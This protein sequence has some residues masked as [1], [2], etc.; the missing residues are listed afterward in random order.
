[1]K[2]YRCCIIRRYQVAFF[3]DG[4]KNH[5]S[6]PALFKR[7]WQSLTGPRA[8]DSDNARLEYM[9]KVILVFNCLVILPFL[10]ISIIGAFTKKTPLDTTIWLAL[11]LL[12]FIGGWIAANRGYRKVGGFITS[13]VFLLV[14]AYGNY[15]GGIDA[16]AMLLYALAII[17]AAI[18]MGW[19]AQLVVLVLSLVSFVGFGFAHHIHLLPAAR[20]AENMFVNRISIVVACLAVIA[21][22]VWFL[23]YQYQ[24]SINELRTSSKKNRALL[25]TISDGVVYS[26]LEGEIVDLNEGAATMFKLPDRQSVLG[27][28]IIEFLAPE[29]QKLADGLHDIL[30]TN[31]STGSIKCTGLL[32]NGSRIFLEINSA[33]FLD[34]TGKPTGFVSTMRDITQ[35]KQI[36]DELAKYREQLENL[37]SERTAELKDAYDEMESFSYSISHDLRSPLRGID[38][39]TSLVARDP[40]NKLSPT[41]LTYIDHIRTSTHRMADLISDLLDFSRLIRHPLSCRETHPDVIA[42]EVKEELLK[43]DYSS[44]DFEISIEKMPVCFADPVLLRQVYFNLLDNAFKYSHK[45]ERSVIKV[46][47]KTGEQNEIIYFVSDNGIGFDM[48]YAEKL[49][50]MFQRLHTDPDYKGTGIGLATVQRIIQRHNGKIWVTSKINE[51]T[52]FY[53]TLNNPQLKTIS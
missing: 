15:V 3:Q 1:M 45:R 13:V 35:R 49:F 21:L 5:R 11:M 39:Y 38:G 50:G 48:Q 33:V 29:D 34:K 16:P 9:T 46:G 47:S 6:R 41:S 20:D 30:L 51:G 8:A 19:R 32:P 7:I 37:V 10:P 24:Q 22:G 12:I 26:N 31:S 52:T 18:L 25:E 27:R 44:S 17:V 40:E 28:N 2:D 36:E 42:S 14:G 4:A 43:N 53:F 23:R